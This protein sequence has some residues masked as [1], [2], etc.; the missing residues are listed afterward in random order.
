M[1]SI[2]EEE[3]EDVPVVSRGGG[4]LSPAS[5]RLLLLQSEPMSVREVNVVLFIILV[6]EKCEGVG[7]NRKLFM[8]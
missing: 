6:G 3:E 5:A 2:R 7:E 4:W 1:E 8:C